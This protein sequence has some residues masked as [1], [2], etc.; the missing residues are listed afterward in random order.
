[1]A[2]GHGE[3]SVR[4]FL[5]FNCMSSSR[6]R[7]HKSP[8]HTTTYGALLLRFAPLT[9]TTLV[10]GSYS[11]QENQEL[12]TGDDLIRCVSRRYELETYGSKLPMF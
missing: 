4:H 10:V 8:S 9:I 11:Y 12:P 2:F 3:Y 1:M 5:R 7:M 6:T